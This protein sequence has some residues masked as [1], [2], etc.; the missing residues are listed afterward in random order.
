[1]RSI[2]DTE[3][4]RIVKGFED[5]TIGR[6]EW[7]H[8]E[9]MIVGLYYLHNSPLEEASQKMRTGILNLLSTGFKVDLSKEMPYHETITIFW[10]KTLEKVTNSNPDLSLE[11]K[12]NKVLELFDKEY[13]LKFYS[14]DMLF[15]DEA[16]RSY[17]GPDLN[18]SLQETAV[19][20]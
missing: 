6:D 13:P 17:V 10:M 11:E 2:D 16:R 15:S 14:R 1:M 20:Y 19:T 3:I 4:R 5:A 18:Q 7:K 9:H 8:A 12:A